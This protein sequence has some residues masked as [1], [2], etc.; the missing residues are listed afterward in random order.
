MHLNFLK[1]IIYSIFLIIVVLLFG[2]SSNTDTSKLAPDFTLKD[3]SGNSVS[4]QQY[5]GKLVLL[6]FW[7]TW[8]TPCRY[9]IPELVKIQDK[10][11]DQGVG[12]PWGF[13]G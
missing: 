8:C 3:L 7:A 11:R 9:S 10:Y 13:S 6:D 2:C 12:N 1:K 4:L 5:R